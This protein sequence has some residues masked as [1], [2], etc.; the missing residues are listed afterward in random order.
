MVN[1]DFWLTSGWHLL[2]KDKA[3]FL[4][5]TE[6]FM[7]AY[8][9]RPEVAPVEESCEAELALHKK[10]IEAPFAIIE[11]NDIKSNFYIYRN[12][13][14]SEYIKDERDGIYHL[15]ILNANYAPVN[16]FTDSKF[17]Q[18]PVDL[19]PQ[20]DRDNIDSNPKSAKTYAK[21]APIGDTATNDLKKSITR[22]TIDIFLPTI[23][24]I[25]V[26]FPELGIPKILTKPDLFFNLFSNK[27][28]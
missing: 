20:L 23:L 5:P 16:T 14:I 1:N 6:D 9:Y 25:N 3:G 2:D 19:Y 28:P 12:D 10:L 18:T 27:I 13:V 26:D 11:K 21:R 15:Y 22:E 4:I 7:K 17:T 24:F 8:Y